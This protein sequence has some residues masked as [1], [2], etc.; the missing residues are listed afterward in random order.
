MASVALVFENV[1]KFKYYI[2]I[3][4]VFIKS[5]EQQNQQKET[6][7]IQTPAQTQKTYVKNIQFDEDKDDR[8]VA[9]LE[10]IKVKQASNM[11]PELAGDDVIDNKKIEKERKRKMLND[12][13]DNPKKYNK[14][15]PF[16]KYFK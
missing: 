1:S 13:K 11:T 15:S 10:T 16:F 3:L 6:P 4:N 7:M 2:T 5:D 12:P 9:N 8:K 14:K